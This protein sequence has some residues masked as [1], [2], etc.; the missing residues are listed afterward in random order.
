MNS[1]PPFAEADAA[2]GAGELAAATLAIERL[3]TTEGD[4][5]LICR[6]LSNEPTAL[7]QRLVLSESFLRTQDIERLIALDAT[8]AVLLYLRGDKSHVRLPSGADGRPDWKVADRLW[9]AAVVIHNHPTDSRRPIGGSFSMG[10][11]ALAQRFRVSELRVAA[12]E[13]TYTLAPAEGLIWHEGWIPRTEAAYARMR[14]S[15]EHAMAVAP[16]RSEERD[17]YFFLRTYDFLMLQLAKRFRFVYDRRDRP[18]EDW[19]NR[20]PGVQPAA[21]MSQSA[22]VIDDTGHFRWLSRLTGRLSR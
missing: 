2:L 10:D 3:L 1:D 20:I 8:G 15:L 4:P 18:R 9:E 5:Q 11:I 21:E 17:I 22:S 6:N 7:H 19:V 14:H 12:L 13:A 16:Q